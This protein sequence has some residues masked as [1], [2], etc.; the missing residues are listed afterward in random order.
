MTLKDRESFRIAANSLAAS[1]G[2]AKFRK[3]WKRQ[4]SWIAGSEDYLAERAELAARIAECAID[5]RIQIA[6]AGMDCDCVKYRGVH[7]RD[8][9]ASVM[10]FEKEY[11]D[12]ENWADG[13]FS[14]WPESPDVVIESSSRDLVLEAY[15][16]G[17][18]HVV[19]T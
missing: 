19:Y 2:R 15:E 8:F 1:M 7:R 3:F 13:P 18:P 4:L 16:D 11:Q 9:P 10:A 6:T 12:T 14:L 5:G 17:H